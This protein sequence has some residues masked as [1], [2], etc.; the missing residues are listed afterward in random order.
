MSDGHLGAVEKATSLT[1]QTARFSIAPSALS[2]CVTGRQPHH[3]LDVL[4]AARDNIPIS[5][6]SPAVSGCE[7]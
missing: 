4:V 1:L 5:F 6:L 7:L 3:S 2:C